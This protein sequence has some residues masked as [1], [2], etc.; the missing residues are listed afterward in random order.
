[1]TDFLFAKPTFI[2]GIMSIVDLFAVAPEY[3]TS[4]TTAEADRNAYKADVA[5]LR[6]DMKNAY[7]CVRSA[8]VK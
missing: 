2:D 1:M 7:S 6:K 4:K 8:Y 5:A 3:N